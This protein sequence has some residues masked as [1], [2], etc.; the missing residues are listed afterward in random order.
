MPLP[1]VCFSLS[2]SLC[3]CLYIYIYNIYIC[4]YIIF[5][6]VYIYIYIYIIYIYNV[7]IYLH[8]VR[9]IKR[10][11]QT[12]RHRHRERERNCSNHRQDFRK[13]LVALEYRCGSYSGSGWWPH[14]GCGPYS[15]DLITQLIILGRSHTHNGRGSKICISQLSK[16]INI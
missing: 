7:F 11:R 16:T 2:L 12:D 5:I 15:L 4:I 3:L 1:T 6:Y 14:V 8:R 10:G 9:K 13:E